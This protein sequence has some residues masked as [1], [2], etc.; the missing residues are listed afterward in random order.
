MII[1]YYKNF[2]FFKNLLKIEQ[3]DKEWEKLAVG[4]Y[5]PA[6]TLRFWG[7]YRQV[8]LFNS[9][10]VSSFPFFSFPCFPSPFLS[11]L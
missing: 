4:P 8:F 5:T 11:L 9:L 3:H 6:V 7:K 1:F 10:R 2:I